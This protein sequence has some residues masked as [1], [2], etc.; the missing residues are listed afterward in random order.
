M[1]LDL[2]ADQGELI[3]PLAF[4]LLSHL[5]QQ[6][7]YAADH[8]IEGL[9]NRSDLV[10]RSRCHNRAEITADHLPH[11]SCQPLQGTCNHP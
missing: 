3:L 8:E 11:R 9:R 2:R 10:F 1:R 7:P 4:L 5:I 6:F